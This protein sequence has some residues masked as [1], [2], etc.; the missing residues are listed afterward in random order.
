MK[1]LDNQLAD[2][3]KGVLRQ[4]ISFVGLALLVVILLIFLGVKPFQVLDPYSKN[5]LSLQ[6]DP[7]KGKGIFEMNCAGCHESTINSQVG[8]S[9]ERISQRKSDLGII[10][11][12]IS[13]QTPPMPQFQPSEEEM[14]D[15]LSYLKKI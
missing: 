4:W 11:Q 2:T 3:K 12:V 15:I 6:G 14:A 1:I 9:L 7:V 10:S 5:V 8:P 13:G